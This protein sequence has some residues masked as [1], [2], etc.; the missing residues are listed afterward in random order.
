[1][2]APLA[3][4]TGEEPRGPLLAALA[5]D[6]QRGAAAERTEIM[7]EY[8]AGILHARRTAS[9]HELAGIVRA[10]KDRA[11]ATLAMVARNAALELT[12]RRRVALTGRV[13]GRKP[14]QDSA[15]SEPWPR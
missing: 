12:A 15:T 6:V 5:E 14:A 13:R 9:R 11:R 2:P 3:E 8:A 7:R 10:L 1:M 4:C